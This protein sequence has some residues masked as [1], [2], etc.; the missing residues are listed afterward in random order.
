MSIQ[1]DIGLLGSHLPALKYEVSRL[2]AELGWLRL[3]SRWAL[4]VPIL[5]TQLRLR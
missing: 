3:C 5:E 4:L 1:V 2:V